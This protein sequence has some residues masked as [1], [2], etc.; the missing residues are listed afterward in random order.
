MTGRPRPTTKVAP[1][2]ATT[3]AGLDTASACL[4]YTD[5]A[6]KLTGGAVGFGEGRY[7]YVDNV[8]I[9]VDDGQ[10]GWTTAFEDDFEVDANGYP[11]NNEKLTHDAAGNLTYDGRYKFVWDAWGRLAEVKR[12]YRESD[13][14]LAVTSSIATMKYDGLGRRIAPGPD[15]RAAP[16]IRPFR[17]QRHRAGCAPNR[18]GRGSPC[19]AIRRLPRESGWAI[20]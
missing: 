9:E 17:G 16:S 13:G 15:N 5:T 19:V 7:S 20:L 4:T 12:A 3:K 2:T 6:G 18:T 8:T 10:G 1:P 11:D 14:D